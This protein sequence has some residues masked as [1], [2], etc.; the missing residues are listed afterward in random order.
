MKN[1]SFEFECIYHGEEKKVYI[2][3]V[4]IYNGVSYEY[5]FQWSKAHGVKLYY[6]KYINKNDGYISVSR[7]YDYFKFDTKDKAMDVYNKIKEML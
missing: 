4:S 5:D 3:D 2:K 6:L 1:K 7:D